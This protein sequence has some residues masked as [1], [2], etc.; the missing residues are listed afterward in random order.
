PRGS[1]ESTEEV[2][3]M[4][5]RASLAHKNTSKWAKR[6]LK[7]GNNVDVDTRRAL[8]AQIKRGDD[9]LKRMNS[10][11]AGEEDD[12]DEEEDLVETASTENDND[13]DN[14]AV[15][16][17]GLFQLSFMK[18]GIEKQREKAKQEA[19]QLLMELEA[20]DEDYCNSD[21]EKENQKQSP[22]KKV[23][24]ASKAEM[25]QVLSEGELVALALKFG[26][27]SSIAVSGDINIDAGFLDGKNEVAAYDSRVSVHNAT[28]ATNNH[29]AA[30]DS[31]TH[32]KTATPPL[33]KSKP[34][35]SV[36]TMALNEPESNPW[37]A[38]HPL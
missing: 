33:E 7:R 15:Q 16:G 2:E 8:S 26:T 38:P 32:K 11:R 37:C 34:S 14:N 30:H 3:R 31:A 24:V 18:R 29:V 10:T 36:P 5:E 25:K 27:S 1:G 28:F 13:D 35:V 6:I 23:K 17:K 4:K 20:D 9:L 19:R 21:D 12:D 22:K